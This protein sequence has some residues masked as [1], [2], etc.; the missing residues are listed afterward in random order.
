MKLR[1]RGNSIRL[2]L[3]RRD[4]S[5]L[6]DRGR[7]GD[8]LRF[9]P[10]RG[11]V[12]TYAVAIGAAPSNRPRVDYHTG[13]LLVIID[14]ADAEEWGRNDRVGFDSERAGEGGFIV[15]LL[16]EKDFA[17]L[18]RTVGDES[19]D[20]F[21]FQNPTAAVCAKPVEDVFGKEVLR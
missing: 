2:R 16:L 11:Q 14:R 8:E 4:L 17:C 7:T 21:A 12:L 18:D 6:L 5:E 13:S 1:I 15:R 20:A 19:E 9:G 10:G 3:D